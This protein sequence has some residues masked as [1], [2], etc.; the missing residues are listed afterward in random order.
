VADSLDRISRQ[1]G[2]GTME[3]KCGERDIYIERE[4]GGKTNLGKEQRS[5]LPRQKEQ[6]YF[7]KKTQAKRYI[8]LGHMYFSITYLSK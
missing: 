7:V 1:G 3:S 5:H 6:I 4:K 8:F 2:E